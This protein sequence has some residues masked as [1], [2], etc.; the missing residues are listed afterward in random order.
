MKICKRVEFL[1]HRD[2]GALVHTNAADI[3]VIF[4]TEDILRI[5]VSF[6]RKMDEASYI[7]TTTAWPDRLDAVMAGERTRVEAFSPEIT[8]G[9]TEIVFRT[10]AVRLV[11][12][13]ECAAFRLYDREGTLLHSDLPGGAY[14]CDLGTRVTHYS[15]MAEEDCF[16]G[17]GE[18]TGEL[19]KNLCFL[20][21]RATDAM[22]YDPRRADTLYKHIP[23]YIRLDR[24]SRKAVG[25]FYHNTFESCFNMGCEKS[26][27]RPRYSYFQ[28]DG[29]D[30]DLFLLAGGSIR[31]ILDQYTVLTGRP[32][33]LPKRALGYQGSSMY[34][35]ELPKGSDSAV[36]DFV[37]TAREEGFPMDG[38]HLSSGYTS[39]DAKRCVFTWNRERFPDPEGF[40]SDMNIR[41][42]Q[43]VP[44][45]KPGVL[46]IHPKFPEWSKRGV[47]AEDSEMPGKPAEGYWW[48]GTGAFWD[49]TNP[50]ARECWKRE[51]TENLLAKGT[52]S[53][54]NDNC[55][56]DSLTDKDA[57]CS[58]DGLG[59]T[60]GELKP[61]MSNLMCLLS[62]E[63][64]RE[65]SGL[66]P[67]TVCRSGSAGIQRYAQTW[68]GDNRTSWA[69]LQYNIPTILGMGLSGQPNEGADIGGFAGPA[70]DEE[71]FVRWVQ[72]GIFQPRFSIHSASSDN[73]VTEP[74]MFR[75]STERIRSAI[76]L[77]YRLAPYLYSCEYEASQNGAPI[78]RP[79]VYEFQNDPNVYAES[80]DYLFG[81]DLLIANVLEPGAM[82]RSVYL[83]AGCCWY[84]WNDR[85]RCYSGG[86]TI[87][88]PVTLDTIPMF[89]REGGCVAMSDTDLHHMSDP[90]MQLRLLIAP[91]GQSTTVLYDD[92]GV[93]EDY[94]GGT[95]RKTTVIV[96]ASQ[97]TT[98]DFASEGSWRDSVE[99]V[100]LELIA[101]EKCPYWVELDGVRLPHYLHRGKYEQA[102]LGWYYSQSRRTVE[103]RYPNPKH[104]CRLTVSFEQF[105]LIGM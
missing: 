3:R 67:Y 10:P 5:R 15:R 100:T 51:L 32:A 77:R 49:F 44:N 33:L 98:V 97:L 36:L 27:Y 89:L 23:F 34:Y 48:G 91:M 31:R 101:K 93:T 16:Y 71:L 66:R 54:W 102:E 50:E 96:T 40:F 92:D 95:Y 83:P 86:Q 65:C 4:L 90:V 105:D 85:M 7:L 78:M 25:M 57:R 74:W 61:I 52:A 14:T 59:G 47:F 38:F 87:R 43:V 104:D 45:V 17:F 94:R 72:Q 103:I 88:V 53:V 18:K 30:I 42:A 29:G 22:G 1:E 12:E 69:S 84:D 64:V 76:A 11:L 13:R 9:E 2:G 70:P 24:A 20:R 79:L 68:A 75:G 37:D 82:E 80:F 35:A 81:R 73:T 19:N 62:N 58:Y 28:A 55:E 60:V 46:L 6:D 26:N 41:G 39:V 99:R 56:Y 8:E 63:A 21:E